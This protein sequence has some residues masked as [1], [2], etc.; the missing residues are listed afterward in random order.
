ML[1]LRGERERKKKYIGMTTNIEKRMIIHKSSLRG[2]YHDNDYLQ[3]S[4]NKHGE[5]SF[6]FYILEECRKD[7]LKEK[8]KVYIF[9]YNTYRGYNGGYNLTFGGDGCFGLQYTEEQIKRSSESRKGSIITKEHRDKISKAIKGKPKPVG[10]GERKQG[11]EKT[12]KKKKTSKYVGVSFDS[13]RNL[14]IYGVEKGD[15]RIKGRART[16]KEAAKLYNDG[17]VL[18]YGPSAKVNI[19]G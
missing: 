15:V 11:V 16:E 3:K 19:I 13:S 4:W 5:E 18:L 9:L 2:N 8:E 14:W 17:A 12:Y 10:Y 7:E 1:E 6:L